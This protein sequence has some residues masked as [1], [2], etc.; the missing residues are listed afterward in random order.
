MQTWPGRAYPLG[1]TF[2]GTGTNF[3]LFSG[4]AERVE[5][6]LVADDGTETRV[7]V[8]EVDAHVWHV[9][10]PGVGPGTRYG[11]RVHGPYD[12]ARG[13]RCNPAKLLLDPY[14]KAMD[15]DVDGDAALFSYPLD[16]P[17]D[18]TARGA[19]PTTTDS[20]G[21]T[22]TSVVVNPFF[23]WGHDRPPATDYHDSVIYEAHVRGM[24]MR[25]P[26]VPPELRGTYAA[27]AQPAVL[28]HLAS[29]GVTAVELMPVHQFVTDPSLRAKGLTNY[30]GYNT[31]GYFAP[32]N[33]Y[34]GYGT[35]GQQVMEFKAMVKALHESGIEVLLDVVYNHTAE[36]NH[37]GP[38]LGFRG[39]D[40]AAYYRLVDDD[41]A[42][43]FDTTGTGNSLL[44]H[45]SAVLQLIMD[46]LRYWVEE[47]HVDGFRFDLAATLARQ[48]HEVDRLSAFFDIVHQDPVV[49]QVKLI[50]EPWD[51]GDGGYQVG[52]FP[53]LWTEWNGRYRD[54]VRDFWRGEPATLPELASRLTGSSDLYE[55]TGRRPVASINFVTA[56]DGFTLT[57][58]VSYNSKHNEANG[59]GNADGE[60]HNRSW[61]CGAE[62]PTDDAGVNRLRARQRR[63]ILVTLLLSQGVPML[64]HGDELGRTQHG[65][66]NAYCQD[67][68]LTWMDWDKPDDELLDFARR[69]VRLR[70]DHPVLR[71]RRFF[72]GT[73]VGALADIEW[74]DLTGDRMDDTD[75][76]T[77][78]ARTV[79]VFLNGDAITETD[80]RGEPIVDDSFLLLLNAHSERL[81]FTLPP[82]GYGAAWTVV[83]DTDDNAVP[84][85]E[86]GAGATLPV[87]GHSVV[88]LTR[89]ARDPAARASGSGSTRPSRAAD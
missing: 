29:L 88:V 15:G 25:H 26:D 77:S 86:L 72:E 56:H 31:I 38:T 82:E 24:T 4:V 41:K 17:A 62:G 5:L 16:R 46:S 61:N 68:E 8:T 58:L 42:H 64:S 34:A 65:N 53:P 52:G 10:L 37:L 23:D 11:Y 60:S 67:N 3:A 19:V 50:A 49:S 7:D 13:H 39:I 83:L 66:N 85:T 22:M 81:D 57:D 36:G 35:R 14:A 1:A 12:P 79:T 45:S 70:R 20:A 89:P 40:N 73:R 54:T 2:D 63:N 78:Y 27:L 47:M 33:G 59:E 30:W 18:A 74:L 87:T 69:T 28:D 44:M 80:G 32:H 48:F 43:Y 76:H 21:H 9:Y 71:R 51:L 84:G 6:C 55:H 75:W